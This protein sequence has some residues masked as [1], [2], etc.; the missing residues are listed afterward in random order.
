MWGFLQFY[1]KQENSF[2]SGETMILCN[3]YF[4]W[5]ILA[6]LKKNPRNGFFAKSQKR[7]KKAKNSLFSHKW[8]VFEKTR[9]F[10]KK[11][12]C[13]ES[14]IF[15]PQLHTKFR[16]NPRR[17]FWYMPWHTNGHTNGQICFYRSLQFSTGDQ[18]TPK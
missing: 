14:S 2:F 10:I 6:K 9:F 16:K 13:D 11:R 4:F 1:K 8:A 17:G 18:N 5:H 12:P 7:P 3:R 15:Y